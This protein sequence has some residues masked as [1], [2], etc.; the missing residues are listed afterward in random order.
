MCCTFARNPRPGMAILKTL[1]GLIPVRALPAGLLVDAQLRAPFKAALALVSSAA[2]R[3]RMRAVLKVDVSDRLAK[4]S[5]PILYLRA[6]HDWLVPRAASHL[7]AK[8]VPAAKVVDFDAPH[9]LLQTMPQQAAR[10]V[11]AFMR[12]CAV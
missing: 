9:F 4:C 5:V 8:I 2:L 6:K 11:A 3:A 7:I 12:H 1:V 10:D